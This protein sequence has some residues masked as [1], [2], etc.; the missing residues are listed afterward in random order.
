MPAI[1]SGEGRQRR[2]FKGY[3]FGVYG[4]WRGAGRG[5][6]GAVYRVAAVAALG[7]L[8]FG[9]DT[10]VVSG[11]LLFIRDDFGLGSFYSDDHNH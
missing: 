4:P 5:K 1:P 2:R 10:G 8:L 9:Y 7:G 3:G 11:A 6:R